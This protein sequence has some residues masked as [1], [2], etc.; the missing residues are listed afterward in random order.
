MTLQVGLWDLLLVLVVSAE[1]L[2]L[3]Y[4]GDPRWKAVF[5]T[6]P[7]PFT[8]TYL[9]I[10][11]PVAATNVLALPLLMLYYQVVR[12]LYERWSV[13]IVP[14]IAL[15]VLTYSIVG[16]VLAQV[17]PSTEATFWLVSAAVWLAGIV[18]LA[19]SPRR[20]EAGH[21][22]PL[23]VYLK[24]PIT[25]ALVA[26]LVSIKS[27][28]AGFATLFPLVGTIAAYEARYSLG[29]VGRQLPVL[30]IAMVPMMVAIRLV[31]P[32]LGVGVALV[33]GW[34]MFLVLY[35]P[36]TWSSWFRQEG[37]ERTSAP[38]A[39]DLGKEGPPW[40]G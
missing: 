37:L 1:A 15:A 35:V 16:A 18:L 9:A 10:G 22:S 4:V 8:I 14:A 40:N 33:A 38:A 21:R 7:L 28:L 13:P 32:L 11:L 23:P 5:S 12:V 26:L 3:A 19:K 2:L 39:R 30:F 24:L 6:L 17:L 36:L 34:L 31:Q 20:T 25:V 27:L 29:T